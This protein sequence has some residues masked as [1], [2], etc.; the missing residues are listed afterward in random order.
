LVKK[1]IKKP[2]GLFDLTALLL[3]C[4]A[5]RRINSDADAIPTAEGPGQVPFSAW[6][7]T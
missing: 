3:D 1:D 5:N 6:Q 4:A 2:P 7:S